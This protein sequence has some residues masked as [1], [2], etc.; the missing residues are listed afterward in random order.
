M[1]V[2]AVFYIKKQLKQ[3]R[4]LFNWFPSVQYENIEKTVSINISEDD[5]STIE[6]Y[7]DENGKRKKNR[8]I[9]TLKNNREIIV[10]NSYYELT[11]HKQTPIIKG[12]YGN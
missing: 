6:P 1:E 3:P 7:V 8:A 10:N 11:N 2:N 5:I 4:T 9:I 12:F